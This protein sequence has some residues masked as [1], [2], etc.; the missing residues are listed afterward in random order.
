MIPLRRDALNTVTVPVSI[1]S[2]IAWTLNVFDPKLEN[3]GSMTAAGSPAAALRSCL[4]VAVPPDRGL[5]LDD[6]SGANVFA[7]AGNAVTQVELGQRVGPYDPPGEYTIN[8][9]FRVISGF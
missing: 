4:Q 9:V 3:R 7:G 2:T 8:L 1:W 5:R 6:A